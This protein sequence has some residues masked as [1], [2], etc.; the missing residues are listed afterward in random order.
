MN[1]QIDETG[2]L[3]KN[4]DNENIA[5][6]NSFYKYHS[7]AFEIGHAKRNKMFRVIFQ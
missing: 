3:Q 2:V 1:L 7:K 4:F 6:E 5:N